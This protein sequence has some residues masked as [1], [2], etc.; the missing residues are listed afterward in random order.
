MVLDNIDDILI[1]SILGKRKQ[2]HLKIAT[3]I[4]NPMIHFH[5]IKSI[6]IM[7]AHYKEY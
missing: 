3:E 4:I 7:N 2:L 1:K 5:I 6:S